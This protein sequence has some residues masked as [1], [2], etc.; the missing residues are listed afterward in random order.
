MY[1]F[2]VSSFLSS[3]RSTVLGQSG[4]KRALTEVRASQTVNTVAEKDVQ[5]PIYQATAGD[6]QRLGTGRRIVRI[7]VALTI[8]GGMGVL[9]AWGIIE[10]RSQAAREAER[11][12]PV[13]VPSRV[14][15]DDGGDSAVILDERTRKRSGV[16]VITALPIR[17]Q[18]QV[19]AYGTVMDLDNLTTLHNRY[20]TALAQIQSA[21]AKLVASKAAFE[22]A[23]DLLKSR[24][25]ALAQLQAAEAAFGVDQAALATAQ[26]QV[27][28]IRATA[29]EEWGPAIGKALVEGDALVSRLIEREAFLIQITLRPGMSIA[30]PP[31]A[32]VQLS[33]SVPRVEVRFLS[34]ASQADPK[35]QG[36][37]FYY[38][39]DAGS[40]LLPGMSV[41]PAL[42]VGASLDGVVVPASAIVWWGGRTWVYLRTG[43]ETFKRHP[44]PTDL[45]ATDAGG[46]V[47]PVAVFPRSPPD[48]VTRGAQ[49]L[50]SEELRAQIQMGGNDLK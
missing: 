27:K 21:Q 25:M 22:R 1:D 11:A 34:V 42:P 3:N 9:A 47:V 26:A 46:V 44:I 23:Q 5:I 18:E 31:T 7:L 20:V 24:S 14:K 30:P 38:V 8:A 4:T 6:V 50:L 37:S 13:Q 35:I 32:T 10:G 12:G 43:A 17:Y 15:L 33:D 36:F 48:L 41:L 39:A 45:P 49:A 19:R 40:R 29:F 16:E 2:D 28:T